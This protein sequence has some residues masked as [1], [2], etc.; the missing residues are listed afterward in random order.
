[1]IFLRA[2]LFN[3]LFYALNIVLSFL[4]I[5][6]LF[7]SREA[8][9]KQIRFYVDSIYWLEK[10]VLGLDYE[11]RGIEHL[12][13]QGSYIVAAKH[14]SA[15]E[16]F[17]L[18]RLW[19]DPA[20]ILKRELIQIPLWGKYLSRSEPIAINRKSVRQAL[21]EIIDGAK[22][23]R[24]QGRVLVIFPQG[25]RV[26]PW[27]TPA[28]KPYKIG[29]A[30][31]HEATG[32]KIV[33]LA[34]NTGLF[35]P[36]RGWVKYPGKVVFQFLPPVAEGLQGRDVI[37]DLETRIEGASARLQEEALQKY[38]ILFIRH[39]GERRD[40]EPQAQNSDI[41]PGP[42]GPGVRRDDG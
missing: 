36:R 24:D 19:K 27:E 10:H 11:V 32:M 17:K 14:Q 1:M 37:N 28:E 12:P 39:P 5:P 30:Q 2:T 42:L 9:F 18:H 3:I 31:I 20:V 38:P 40:P 41:D 13:A 33:P 21:R 34:L 25:T 16:T 8:G 15:Y 35:W 23:V 26:W 7:M 22:A 29:I 6:T 4:C